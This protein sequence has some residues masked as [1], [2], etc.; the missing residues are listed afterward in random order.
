MSLINPNEIY[1]QEL[2]KARQQYFNSE[3]QKS[4]LLYYT[5]VLSLFQESELETNV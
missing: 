4:N 5:E 2:N 3:R 1:L